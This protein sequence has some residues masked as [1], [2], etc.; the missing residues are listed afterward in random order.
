V[1]VDVHANAEDL[2]RIRE[3]AADATHVEARV[4]LALIF[5]QH[6]VRREV[7][8]LLNV[9]DALGLHGVSRDGL[10]SHRQFLEVLFT[11]SGRDDNL[12]EHR[13]CGCGLLRNSLPR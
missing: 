3:S 1:A 2:R 5:G 7:R 11:P 9:V 4:V 6:D 8:D 12:F 13:R 10:D